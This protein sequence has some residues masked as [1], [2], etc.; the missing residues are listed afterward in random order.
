MG[1]CRTLA[2]NRAEVSRL[3]DLYWRVEKSATAVKLLLPWFPSK[4]K[5]ESARCTKELYEMLD[6]YVEERKK[7]P[8]GLGSDAID[9]MIQEELPNPEIIQVS[10]GVVK[11][12]R[13]LD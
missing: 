11:S 6:G 3:A 8:E 10:I 1:S 13:M 9:V 4:D 2:S 12:F 5:R 7:A